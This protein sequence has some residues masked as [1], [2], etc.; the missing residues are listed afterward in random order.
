MAACSRRGGPPRRRRRRHPASPPWP[1]PVPDAVRSQAA[2][3]VARPQVASGAQEAGWVSCPNAKIA[4][5]PRPPASYSRRTSR[6]QNHP[7]PRSSPLPPLGRPSSKLQDGAAP[8]QHAP[9]GRG[10][11]V[12]A[13][14]PAGAGLQA[15]EG[16]R[17]GGHPSTAD[18]R[19]GLQGSR[20]GAFSITNLALIKMP[21]KVSGGFM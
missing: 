21:G 6:S 19:P 14:R 17:A 8:R 10:G 2:R 18:R 11:G 3:L 13:P 7:S 16:G 4:P 20:Q 1:P 5:P 9:D 15:E 12:Q